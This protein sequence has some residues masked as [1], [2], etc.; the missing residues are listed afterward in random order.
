MIIGNAVCKPFFAVFCSQCI[1]Q[2][3]MYTA[4]GEVYITLGVTAR[5][6]HMSQRKIMA[7]R[8]FFTQL[9]ELR[10]LGV[11]RSDVVL[12]DI[13]EFLCTLVYEDLILSTSKTQSGI[14]GRLGLEDVQ[15]KFS[16]SSDA[17]NID[18]GNPSKDTYDS[19]ILILG[20]DSAHREAGL[21]GDFIFYRYTS[22]EVLDKFSVKCG[23]KFSKTKHFKRHEHVF[24][25]PRT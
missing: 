4:V 19:L 20:K 11:V 6:F 9:A 2:P 5:G 12:G 10:N 16:N 23:F 1:P 17:K 8:D 14:D 15:I 13:G 7:I 18:L 3:P 24:N 21:E 22:K 25:F